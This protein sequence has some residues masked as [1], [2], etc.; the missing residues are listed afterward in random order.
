VF[1]VIAGAGHLLSRHRRDSTAENDRI[2][3]GLSTLVVGS[4]VYVGF[5]FHLSY[6]TRP[7]YFVVFLAFAATCLEIITAALGS[8]QTVLRLTCAIV[9]ICVS[10]HPAWA[11]LQFRQTNIDAVARQLEASAGADDLILINRWNYAISFRRYYQGAAVCATIPPV[12]DLR[13][14]RMDLVYRDML[15]EAPMQPVLQAMEATL[16]GGHTVWLIGALHLVKPGETPLRPPSPT[17][18]QPGAGEFFEAWSQQA[19]FLVQT[20]AGELVRVRVPLEQPVIS[21]ENVPLSA[22]RG[23]RDSG[24]LSV[25]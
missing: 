13:T 3:F 14:Q 15:A 2:I 17:Y 6:M 22:I 5:L 25:R 21:F 11:A 19:A 18:V 24:E 10:I 12:A 4:A 1:A 8:M 9:V 7:W 23:W 16:R 20:H